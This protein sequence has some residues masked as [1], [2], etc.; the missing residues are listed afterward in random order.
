[1][2]L[3]KGFLL[4]AAHCGIKRKKLDLG[5]IYCQESSSA[6]GFFTTN[7]NCSYSVTFSKKNISNP[8]RAVLV[9]S[10][11]ANCFTH[12]QGLKDT[13]RIAAQLASSLGVKKKNIL[14]ASTGI[15]GKRLP[16]DKIIKE[17]PLLIKNLGKKTRKF[18]SSILTTDTFTK[19]FCT[20]L[21]LKKGEATILGFAKGAG[22][23]HPHLATMLAF[24]LTDVKCASRA[25]KKLTKEAVE[26]SFNVINVDGCRSTND[27]VFLLSSGK[28]P[29]TGRRERDLFS[30]QLRKVCHKLAMMIVK[31]GEGAS[32]FVEIEVTG[33]QS[34][35]EA[36]IAASSVASST[37]FQCALYGNNS[38]WGRVIAA[39][40][41]AGIKVAENI[42]I[43]AGNLRSKNIHITINL[44]RGRYRHKVYTTDLTPQYVKINAG[45]S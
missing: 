22:M 7:V 38:N 44:K 26:D 42:S 20:R 4:S 43:K 45:Y 33:A 8:I 29:L 40:G 19:V 5:L 2:K 41:Q 25:F 37:L 21:K 18:A 27:S 14:F 34:K 17:I 3:P 6:S 13:E 9:N 28:V 36:K 15:I 24:I 31:D 1:M 39:L 11:N 16:K 32:K 30:K 10:G 23:I 35:T 12:K